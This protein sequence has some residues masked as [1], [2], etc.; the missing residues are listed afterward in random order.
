MFHAFDLTINTTD[1]LVIQVISAIVSVF[2][3]SHISDQS[4]IVVT[5]EI[6]INFITTLIRKQ[7]KSNLQQQKI[8]KVSLV[9]HITLP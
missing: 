7:F 8:R 2:N 1:K 6:Q 3:V 9:L 4:H 5:L